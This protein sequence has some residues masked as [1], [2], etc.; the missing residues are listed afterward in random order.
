MAIASADRFDPLT[1]KD[2][3]AAAIWCGIGVAGTAIVGIIAFGEP[4]TSLRLLCLVLIARIV[5]L[6][7]V[8]P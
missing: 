8:S 4:R 2:S 5:G 6:K 1:E 3:D 7:L